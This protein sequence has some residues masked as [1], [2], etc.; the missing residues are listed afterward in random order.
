MRRCSAA[1]ML[2]TLL[3]GPL[4][5]GTGTLGYD[6]EADPAPWVCDLWLFPSRSSLARDRSGV[7][8]AHDLSPVSGPFHDRE[9]AL[10]Q[11]RG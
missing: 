7:G 4:L 3:S 6:P 11:D 5:A 2:L 1:L 8:S 9:G 10:L